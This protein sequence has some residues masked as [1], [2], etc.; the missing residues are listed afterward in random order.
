MFYIGLYSAFLL[1]NERLKTQKASE[2]SYKIYRISY[3]NILM[4]W[5]GWHGWIRNILTNCNLFFVILVLLPLNFNDIFVATDIRSDYFCFGFWKSAWLFIFLKNFPWNF[6]KI[7]LLRWLINPDL[8]LRSLWKSGL[9]PIYPVLS[10]YREN[11]DIL[12][13]L[14]KTCLLYTYIWKCQHIEI[15]YIKVGF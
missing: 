3:R 14:W 9:L 2:L 10:K 13:S 4:D 11:D 7:P 5:H 15:F 1:K 12:R 8:V 6:Y